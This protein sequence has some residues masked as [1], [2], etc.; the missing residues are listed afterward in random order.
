MGWGDAAVLQERANKFDSALILLDKKTKTDALYRVSKVSEEYR[1]DVR[2]RLMQIKGVRANASTMSWSLDTYQ[3]VAEAEALRR[4]PKL[5][6]VV[7]EYNV[8]P[9]TFENIGPEIGFII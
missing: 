5:D 1:E 6:G 8:A 7:A 9:E 2:K 3:R 4:Q